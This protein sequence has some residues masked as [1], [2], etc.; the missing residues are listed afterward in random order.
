VVDVRQFHAV[1]GVDAV[2]DLTWQ[3]V[4]SRNGVAG[5]RQSLSLREPIQGDGY[6]AVVAA[7]SRL[8]ARA[9]EV[10]AASFRGE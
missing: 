4:N 7:E 8:L 9:A 6:N 2:L 10:M 3:I 5:S 1:S